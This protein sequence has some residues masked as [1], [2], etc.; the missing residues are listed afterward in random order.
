MFTKC[1][2]LVTD[3]DRSR[4]SG[5]Y[6]KCFHG[7]NDSKYVK[8][9]LGILQWFILSEL[10]EIEPQIHTKKSFGIASPLC[11]H[12]FVIAQCS[13]ICTLKEIVQPGVC[14]EN[15]TECCFFKTLMHGVLFTL[16]SQSPTFSLTVEFYSYLLV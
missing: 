16:F 8:I 14:E 2:V 11:V 3:G 13:F 6:C 15:G 10:I 12:V 5:G 1:C 9:F 4:W 7:I